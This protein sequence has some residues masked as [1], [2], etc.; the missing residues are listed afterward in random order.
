[1]KAFSMIPSP[2]LETLEESDQTLR[3]PL[4]ELAEDKRRQRPNISEREL[5]EY[6]AYQMG[7]RGPATCERW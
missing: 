3:T 7:Y 6:L 1:M 2:I 4:G 5:A